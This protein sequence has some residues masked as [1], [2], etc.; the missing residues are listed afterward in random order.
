MNL[1]AA[2]ANDRVDQ[3]ITLVAQLT[4]RITAE[5]RAFEARRPQDAQAGLAET[6]RLAN[7][8]RHEATRVRR[9]PALIEAAEPARRTRL[10]E[11]VTAFEAVL[12]RHA[13]A[14][15]AAKIVTEGLVR[16][17]AEEVAAARPHA[18]GY[19]PGAKGAYA[20]PIAYNQRA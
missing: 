11:A 6:Q 10:R 14:L 12:A 15:E 13:R 3:L 19:G 18:A 1:S 16:A 5:T 8:Y 7:L 4:T 2:D 9:E 20:G 17:V